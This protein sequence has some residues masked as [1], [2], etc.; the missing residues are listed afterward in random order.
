MKIIYPPVTGQRQTLTYW[1]I[2]AL[3]YCID[4][5]VIGGIRIC[6]G[7]FDDPMFLWISS[8]S[9][10]LNLIAACSKPPN[11]DNHPKASYPQMQQRDQGAG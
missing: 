11:K 6:F 9:F 8:N 3:Y 1:T 10:P 4:Y 2:R 7:V 5:F